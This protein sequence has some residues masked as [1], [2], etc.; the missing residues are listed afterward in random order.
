VPFLDRH[1]DVSLG[2]FALARAAACPILPFFVPLVDGPARFRI[3]IE[4]PLSLADWGSAVPGAV[5]GFASQYETYA[6]RYPSST[7]WASSRSRGS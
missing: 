1:L 3:G 7:Y 4:A 5:R 6:R 2:A